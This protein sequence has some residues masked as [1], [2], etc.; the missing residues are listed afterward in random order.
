MKLTTACLGIGAVLVVLSPSPSSSAQRA[1]VSDAIKRSGAEVAAAG[2][3]LARLKAEVLTVFTSLQEGVAYAEAQSHKWGERGQHETDPS[4]QAIDH[5]FRDAFSS[6][7]Q[8]L[9]HAIESLRGLGSIGERLESDVKL[10]HIAWTALDQAV[11]G[12]VER[13]KKP[14][15]VADLKSGL[16]LIQRDVSVTSTILQKE[17]ELLRARTSSALEHGKR[18]RQLLRA[19]GDPQDRIGRWQKEVAQTELDNNAREAR[20]L[21]GTTAIATR[22][23]S[24]VTAIANWTTGLQHTARGL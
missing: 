24:T 19:V 21:T 1:P 15:L 20:E 13:A 9:T 10:L 3:Q 5:A 11:R 23:A 6:H 7:A 8:Q 4:M 17:Q 16:D 2:Q 12:Q 18:V 22:L 14:A